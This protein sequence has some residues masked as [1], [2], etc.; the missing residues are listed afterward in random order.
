MVG[1]PALLLVSSLAAPSVSARVWPQV[2]LEVPLH[3]RLGLQLDASARTVLWPAPAWDR[4]V[5]T[6]SLGG[7]LGAGF[8]LSLGTG[9]VARRTERSLLDV[10]ELRVFEQASW[11]STMGALQLAARARLEHRAV[12]G[13]AL[14][15]RVRVQAKAGVVTPQAVGVYGL[16]ESFVQVH[17]AGTAH[18]GLEQQRFQVG[19]ELPLARG[20]SVDLA[21]L[22]RWVTGLNAP[23]EWQQVVL[24]TFVV[25][26]PT[27]GRTLAPVQGSQPLPR[28]DEAR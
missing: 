28:A 6:V 21:F 8:Q 14:L 22:E 16:L 23:A 2:R 5:D 1:L 3:P 20:L 26:V 24:M 17:D 25:Q 12:V 10:T 9:W 11:A 4:T 18:A 19:V 7:K 13:G 15:H 27:P